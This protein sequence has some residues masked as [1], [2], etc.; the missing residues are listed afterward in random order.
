MGNCHHWQS[1]VKQAFDPDKASDGG[2]SVPLYGEVIAGEEAVRE[3]RAQRYASR[4]DEGIAL[5]VLNMG[6]AHA[7]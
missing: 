3:N 1:K 7:N 2:F 6:G 5:D 4:R